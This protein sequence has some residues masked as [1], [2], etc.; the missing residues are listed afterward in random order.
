MSAELIAS[1]AGVLLSLAF[2]YAPGVKGKFG[3]LGK[4]QKA[5]VMLAAL[6]AVTAGA[7]G[8]ACVG[9]FS[10]PVTCDQTGVEALVKYFIQAA[11][12]NQATFLVA[13]KPFRQRIFTTN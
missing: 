13:V 10:V 11:I 3:A 5:L 1:V 12:T 8:L 2:G 9:W 7:F 4:E 6:F